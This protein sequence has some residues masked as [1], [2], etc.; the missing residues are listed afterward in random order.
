M[1]KRLELPEDSVASLA[2]SS[3]TRRQSMSTLSTTK[4]SRME[5]AISE[6]TVKRRI[7]KSS[8][9]NVQLKVRVLYLKLFLFLFF[10]S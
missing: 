6:K 2:I 8:Q 1:L 9:V 4:V 7:S 5:R 3:K 10:N